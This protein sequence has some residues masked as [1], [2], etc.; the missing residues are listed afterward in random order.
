MKKIIST[1]LTALFAVMTVYFI[2]CY[3]NVVLNNLSDTGAI[4][5]FNIF[6]IMGGM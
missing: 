6:K 5:E 4:W 1:I 3:G 2:A